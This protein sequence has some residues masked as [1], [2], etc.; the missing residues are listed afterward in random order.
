MSTGSGTQQLGVNLMA[1]TPEKIK[2]AEDALAAVLAVNP[3]AGWAHMMAAVADALIVFHRDE[4][5]GE[6]GEDAPERFT[7]TVDMIVP[8]TPAGAALK[9]RAKVVNALSAPLM[10]DFLKAEAA[11]A[12]AQEGEPT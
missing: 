12:E 2:A 4:L 1:L 10:L 8:K 3:N 11:V 6:P 7:L 9:E 5:K